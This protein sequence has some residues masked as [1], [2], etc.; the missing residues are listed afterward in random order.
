MCFVVKAEQIV[1]PELPIEPQESASYLWIQI[2]I[3][4]HRRINLAVL[5][6]CVAV[7]DI[8]V[9]WCIA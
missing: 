8:C 2:Y 1:N 6:Q 5:L 4:F 9:K 7:G 3:K